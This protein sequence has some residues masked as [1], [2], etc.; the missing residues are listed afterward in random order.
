MRRPSDCC[1]VRD[2]IATT[3][4]A[5]LLCAAAAV[6]AAD[7]LVT[8]KPAAVLPPQAA[9][10]ARLALQLARARFA[11]LTLYA[12]TAWPEALSERRQTDVKFTVLVAGDAGAQPEV[13]LLIRGLD[14][15]VPMNDDGSDGDLSA[16]DRI[17]SAVV[18]FDAADARA[19][20]CYDV[21]ASS[22]TGKRTVVSGVRRLCV[23]RLPIGTAASDFS[24]FNVV[25]FGEGNEAM[26]VVADEALIRVSPNLSDDRI[27]AI[28]ALVG[29]V[30][31][32]SLPGQNI[33]QIRLRG[34]QTAAELRQTLLNLQRAGGVLLAVPNAIGGLQAPPVVPVTTSDPLLTSQSNLERIRARH[35]WGIT[36]GDAAQLSA[37]IDT[38]ADF[39]HPDFWATSAG[40]DTRFATS[41]SNLVAADCTGTG[42]VTISK[43]TA[44]HATNVCNAT[45]A[46]TDTYG[47][48]TLAAGLAVTATDNALGV[49]GVT[50]QGRLLVVRY[51][52]SNSTASAAK[53]LDGMNY[54]RAQGARILS[55]ST[56]MPAA[57]VGSLVCPIVTAAESEG[58]LV[59][60]AA[61]NDGLTS[62]NYPAACAGAMPV[63]NSAVNGS[64]QDV[65]HTG[66][67]A[68][69]YGS[70]IAIAAPGTS[71]PSTA[72]T[73]A[74]CGTCDPAYTSATGFATVTGTSFST[75]LAAG[76]AA[77]V[78][79]RSPSIT[80]ADLRAL[81]ASSGVALQ[82]P[83]AHIHRIDLLAALLT[84]NTAPTAINFPGACI[85]ENTDTT[86]GVSAGTLTTVDAD[87]GTTAHEYA[88]V[89]GADAA[90]FSIDVVNADQLMLTDGVLDFETKPSYIV[91]VR[92]TD[93]GDASFEQDIVVAVC[94]DLDE[95]PLVSGGPFTLPENSAVGTVVG[96]IVATDPEG[97]P[98]SYSI[99]SG[100][101]GTAFAISP[102][103]QITV[104]NS[105]ALDFET[106]PV[107]NLVITVS[108]G[109]NI[110][111]FPVTVNLT[112]VLEIPPLLVIGAGPGV[113]H[114]CAVRQGGSV[115]CWGQNV[116]GQLG[117]GTT[118]SSPTPV[119]IMSSLA[120]AAVTGWGDV[121]DGANDQAHT[122]GLTSSGD[123]Y[124]WGLNGSGELGASTTGLCPFSSPSFPGGNAPCSSVPVRVND[125]LSGPTTYA[126]VSAGALHTCALDTNGVVFCWGA[127]GGGQLGD[128]TTTPHTTPS[129]VASAS[130]TFTEVSSGET[131]TCAVATGGT[132]SCWGSNFRGQLGRGDTINSTTP[133]AVLQGSTLLHSLDTGER[134]ACAL[135]SS[136]AA[137][138]WGENSAGQLGSVT[139]ESC[140]GVACSTTPVA[141]SG[142][143]TFGQ[144]S[145]GEF[146]TCGVSGTS[147][148]CWG[149]NFSGQLGNGTLSPSTSPV[150]VSDPDTGP[151]SWASVHAGQN[152][153]C[154]VTTT[155]AL[156]CWGRNNQG[157]LGN[158]LTGEITSTRKPAAVPEP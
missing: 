5:L 12:P 31:V 63:A 57:F 9:D 48:G 82:S 21:L 39:D 42:C 98:I 83:A 124:C 23:S 128:G 154:A 3:L 47:H 97:G 16:G 156:Y 109:T 46:A 50:W 7:S 105:L 133:I 64:D 32:G 129:P 88:V 67:L 123:I 44:C 130:G 113:W 103:G 90:K 72:R 20:R 56:A 41:G 131:F 80:N 49:A 104:A 33:Y 28:A 132:V 96:N 145:A 158:G 91:R 25:V 58:R 87:A 99:T 112:D 95:P 14:R 94:N 151:V 71:V 120:F 18:R 51:A 118:T 127:N 29:G 10:R 24:A 116:F 86:G 135:S 150:L 89:G 125:P 36:T 19:G 108:D 111:L 92:S 121:A 78:L 76:A 149:A 55:I 147:I 35:A 114:T 38:G 148:Y 69:N 126:A 106:T 13:N 22:L 153:T 77:L 79:A 8:A 137:Y 53:L 152:H 155:S 140:G 134:H 110:V 142:S 144:I 102:T 45:N 84:L 1:R 6:S 119:P 27:E 62:N 37:V 70:W 30:V 54:A 74:A 73:P 43:P 66:T 115:Y 15:K 61:G 100:N 81:L 136:G 65:I 107:F 101:T 59:V 122:C 34:P 146:H 85:P 11:P 157:Q 2:V 138:C 141:V 60:A 26:P 40:T 143:L 4:A 17:Y 117:N 75:P 52:A 93:V 68:S 139:A